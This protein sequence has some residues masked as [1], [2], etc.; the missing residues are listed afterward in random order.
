MQDLKDKIREK[1]IDGDVY[2]VTPFLG[3]EGFKIKTKLLATLAPSVGSAL[4][5]VPPGAKSVQ[6][7]DISNVLGIDTMDRLAK[8]LDERELTEFILRL[9]KSTQCNRQEIN[10]EFFDRHFAAAYHTMWKV[11]MFVL[12]VNYGSFFGEDG[13]GTLLVAAVTPGSSPSTTS[14]EGT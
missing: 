13:I 3:V 2:T 9:L 12:E 6:D 14:A 8:V 1:E 5:S 11:V 10:K 4:G 7:V